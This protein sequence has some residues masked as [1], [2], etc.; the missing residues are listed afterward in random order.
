MNQLYLKGYVHNVTETTQSRSGSTNYFNFS[1]QVSDTRKRRA[2]CY[3]TTKQNLIAGFQHSRQPISLLNVT[4]KPSLLDP[5]ERHLILGKKSRIEPVNNDDIQFKYDDTAPP[6]NQ[7]ALTTVENVRLLNENQLATVKGILTLRTNSIRDIIMKNGFLVPMLDRC[8]ITDNTGTIPLTLWGDLIKQ[9]ANK[10]SYSITHVRV[11]QY[12]SAKYLTTT[13]STTITPADEHYSPPSNEF[14]NSLFDAKTISADRI[15]LAD[16]FKTWLSC[17]KCQNLLTEVTSTSTTVLKCPNCNAFQPASS[18]DTN[19]SV[20]IAVRD[21]KHELLW[22]KVFTPLLLEMLN[23]PSTDVNLQSP[24]EKIYEQ[25]FK[26]RNITLH[27]S[28]TSD[29]VKSI[30]F[31]AGENS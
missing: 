2:V 27:C 19:A 6:E 26:L 14:F 8:T 29:I 5:S 7:T 3:D 23:H 4:E 20:R 13:P 31:D 12:D 22:L 16:T 18:C 17:S 11:K 1:L 28:N 25:L 21:S 15:R 10:N 24:Q 30:H 9:V